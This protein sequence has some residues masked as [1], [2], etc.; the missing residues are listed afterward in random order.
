MSRRSSTLVV[1]LAALGA[2]LLAACRGDDARSLPP[3]K[4]PPDAE[5]LLAAGDSTFWIASDSTGIRLRGSPMLLARWDGRFHEVY[6]A[7]DDRSYYDAVFV[8]QRVWRRDLLT[9]D[10]LLVFEDTLVARAADAYA[11]ANPGEPRLGADEE[12]SDDPATS[13]TTVIDVV[14]VLGPWLVFERHV[15]SHV[16]GAAERHVL[17][18]GVLDLRSGERATLASL[19]GASEASR[20]AAEG[21]RMLARALDTVRASGDARVHEALPALEGLELEE[22]S[23]ALVAEKDR[24]AVAFV[25]P[26]HGAAAGLALPLDP[27]VVPGEPPSWWRD[28]SA[29][30]PT[31]GDSTADRWTGGRYE[32]TARYDTTSA[33]LLSIRD[34]AGREFTV[35]RLPFPAHSLWRLDDP[36]LDGRERRALLRAF[37]ESAL[38]SEDSRVAVLP[39]VMVRPA[40]RRR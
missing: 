5:F 7:D 30:L 14:D 12:G 21:R 3:G 28:A 31:D 32:V 38:Y 17:E 37:D 26:G 9:G 22:R 11:A 2:G 25:I 19:F 40:S 29:P 20:L 13:V 8:G 39:R 33:S 36:P 35:G 6:V 1:A 4:R 27:I 24:P 15:D 16:A 34:S 10:S 18:Q 23:F